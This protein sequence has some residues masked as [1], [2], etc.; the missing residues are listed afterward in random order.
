MSR[1]GYIKA[2]FLIMLGCAI[3]AVTSSRSIAA[4]AAEIR[5]RAEQ[6]LTQLYN[7]NEVAR[8]FGRK[9]KGI[10][11]FPEITKA[12]IGVG[13]SYGEG[14]LLIDGRPVEYYAV[15][16]GSLGLTLGAQ[17]FSQVLMFMTDES[18]RKF[19]TSKGWEAGVDGSV[20]AIK[21]GAAGSIDTTTAQDP[22]VG[23]IFGQAGL[24][25][26]ASFSGAKY[27]RV[28]R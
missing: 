15:G 21:E 17:S 13:G 25:F 23:F 16:S 24:M 27:T 20:V 22:I 5:T 9:A 19:R 8:E 10:L 3:P 1:R 4:T 7:Q 26:D 2:A 14:V 6:A 28:R 18:L 11:V 12:G